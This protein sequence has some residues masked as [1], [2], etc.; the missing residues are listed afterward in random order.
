MSPAA[1][2]TDTRDMQAATTSE[3]LLPHEGDEHGDMQGNSADPDTRCIRTIEFQ[4]SV[5]DDALL[6]PL[7]SRDHFLRSWS[8]LLLNFLLQYV[9]LLRIAGVV[10]AHVTKD[11]RTL[12]GGE[13]LCYKMPASQ[14]PEFNSIRPDGAEP[15][16]VDMSYL[17]CAPDEVFAMYNWSGLDLDGDGTWSIEEAESVARRANSSQLE[18]DGTHTRMWA[19]ISDSAKMVLH[20]GRYS[21]EP[22]ILD[23]ASTVLKMLNDY[24][25]SIPHT[26]FLGEIRPFLDMCLI[27][28]DQLCG[29]IVWR[30][31][32]NRSYFL[33]LFRE[34]GLPGHA[35]LPF[36]ER[37][38]HS[39]GT[40]H[41]VMRLCKVS[42]NEICPSFFTVA[43]R[44]W[45]AKRKEMCGS[46]S[47][48]SQLQPQS[49]M[50]TKW[51]RLTKQLLVVEFSKYSEYKDLQLS[52][53]YML[54]LLLILILWS[55][56]MMEE[57]RALVRWWRVLLGAPAPGV[58]V[59]D[60]KEDGESDVAMSDIAVRDRMLNIALSLGPR[61]AISFF[62]LYLGTQY[63][64]M[65]RSYEDLILNSLALTF[66][67]TI[68]EMAFH[69]FVPDRRKSWIAGANAMEAAP[70]RTID[71]C[72]NHLLREHLLTAVI[73]LYVMVHMFYE[74]RRQHGK[75]ELAEAFRCTCQ[76]SGE[77]CMAAEVVGGYP[78]IGSTP[79]FV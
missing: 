33:S 28:D 5:Y 73:V 47:T 4:G 30:R 69:A 22:G 42:I 75:C 63:L 65:S 59:F 19:S 57:L 10:E 72:L 46:P 26:V 25:G 77:A 20:M 12:Y 27:M 64:L 11:V 6:S 38:P 71:H 58:K 29:N 17:N 50:I 13:G 1:M 54:F 70:H 36:L 39:G 49:E 48:S 32:F 37:N 16:P 23:H 53:N 21:D 67:I 78:S 56:S 9:V 76:A 34:S 24:N 15:L 79:G 40:V 41:D 55:M 14:I 3:V 52:S 66:L 8:M 35:P 45:T 31:S 60:A 62:I 2:S 7:I 74:Y 43:F 44:R 18:L 68:D 51:D 61:T